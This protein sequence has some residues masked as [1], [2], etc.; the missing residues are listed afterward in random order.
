CSTR[1]APAWRPCRCRGRRS[2][3]DRSR[4]TNS[5]VCAP[6]RKS[7][8]E[9]VAGMPEYLLYI[10]GAWRG[11]RGGT[12]DVVSPSSGETFATVAVGDPADV[13]DAVRAAAGAWPAWSAASPF[14]RGAGG[15]AVLAA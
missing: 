1:P 4:W 2:G 6:V 13:D 10:H 14:E 3:C 5:A 15:E 11:R 8:H 12:G 7:P 9:G